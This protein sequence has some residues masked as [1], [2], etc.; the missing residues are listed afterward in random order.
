LQD[1][2][3]A[4][5]VHPGT[6]SR[7]L[8]PATRS[9]VSRLTAARVTAAAD[10][11]G[12]TP[13]PV[14]RSLRTA[15]SY[16]VGIVVPDIANP[17]FPL[18]IRGVEARLEACG[19]ELSIVNTDG[20]PRR[21]RRLIESLLRRKV[22]G[23]LVATARRDDPLLEDLH[24]RGVALVL[25]NRD[26]DGLDVPSVTSAD[27]EGIRMLV[28]HLSS[29]GHQRVALVGG[30]SST[31]TGWRRTRAF[32]DAVRGHGMESHVGWRVEANAWSISGGYAAL[33]D[34]LDECSTPAFTAIVAA[35]DL[36]ALGCCDVL[37]E[38]GLTPGIDISVSGFNGMDFLDRLAVPLTS[39]RIPH[40]ALGERAAEIL[41]ALIARNETGTAQMSVELPVELIP[42][43]STGP[44]CMNVAVES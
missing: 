24:A 4:A 26:T 22:D 19:F 37:R 15:R 8:N 43:A 40:R 2:A 11:L 23:L 36:L 16:S 9:K 28:A 44:P 32:V 10:R 39:V 17:L 29:L 12:Y 41:L 7:A 6:A 30:P 14:A 38:R 42:R 31:S 25:L 13:D 35:N 3:A 18:V 20:D 27:G 34:L 33:S 5:G 1:V 21:E